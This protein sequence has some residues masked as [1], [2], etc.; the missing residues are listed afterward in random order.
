[1][2]KEG[3]LFS[4]FLV[5]LNTTIFFS[6][7]VVFELVESVEEYI[8]PDRALTTTAAVTIKDTLRIVCLTF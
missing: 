4:G 1:M 7:A 8:Q 6:D 5:I 3:G 2:E